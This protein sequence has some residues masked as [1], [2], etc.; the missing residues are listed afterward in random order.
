MMNSGYTPR[1]SGHAV[2]TAP[3]TGSQ[4]AK[5]AR[6][7]ALR[8]GG[9]RF[10]A[11]VISA[12]ALALLAIVIVLATVHGPAQV[13][14][15]CASGPA[16]ADCTAARVHGAHPPDIAGLTGTPAVTILAAARYH[17]DRPTA[18][19][20]SGRTVWVTSPYGQSVTELAARSGKYVAHFGAGQLTLSGPNAIAI[21]QGHAWVVNTPGSYITELAIKTGVQERV[22][23]TGYNSHPDA[24]ALA[25]SHLW[26]ANAATNSVK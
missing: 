8:T 12:L 16:A 25:G 21:G 22:I 2:R 17:F 15:T 26:V 7:A 1:H 10:Q 9:K 20:V 3:R 11:A 14:T 18:V 4:P 19:A 23:P 5:G 6:L 13:R 24:I